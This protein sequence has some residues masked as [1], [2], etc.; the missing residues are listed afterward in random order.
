MIVT[1]QT[2]GNDSSSHGYSPAVQVNYLVIT[3]TC[4]SRVQVNQ[5]CGMQPERP[6]RNVENT[7]SRDVSESFPD[8]DNYAADD[9]EEQIESKWVC[10]SGAC[11]CASWLVMITRVFTL[12]I[13]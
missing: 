5:G 4:L 2:S 11:V 3:V 8:M 10:S 9:D 13:I 1:W 7:T 12:L 6:R